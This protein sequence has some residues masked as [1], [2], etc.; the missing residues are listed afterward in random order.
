MS[1]TLRFH[2]RVFRSGDFAQPGKS[3]RLVAP[4]VADQEDVRTSGPWVTHFDSG[5]ALSSVLTRQG[6]QHDWKK[7]VQ[8]LSPVLSL[9]AGVAD[10]GVRLFSGL[11]GLAGALGACLRTSHKSGEEA[12]NQ[13]SRG[14]CLAVKCGRDLVLSLDTFEPEEAQR[15][16]AQVC[17]VP[18]VYRLLRGFSDHDRRWRVY[19]RYTGLAGG[20]PLGACS[21][22]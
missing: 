20:H 22:S 11:T 7:E 19:S 9:T 8:G 16:R 5:A 21:F 6:L 3:A 18:A 13:R 1:R 10:P 14:R 2:F 17:L 12:R 15:G 4:C